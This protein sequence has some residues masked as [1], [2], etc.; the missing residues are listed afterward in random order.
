[1][2]ARHALAPGA[3]RAGSGNRHLG[4]VGGVGVCGGVGGGAS[5]GGGGLGLGLVIGL[6]ALLGLGGCTP[7]RAPPAEAS[8]TRTD[9]PR[10]LSDADRVFVLAAAGAGLYQLE[11]ARLA[12]Q[13]T[14]DP[15]VRNYAAMMQ[16]QYSLANDELRA[17]ARSRGV[18]WPATLPPARQAV[19]TALAAL[20]PEFF[21]RRYVEQTG[22]ADHQADLQLFEAAGRAL[23]DAALRQWALRRV[24]VLQHHL[25]EAQKL[26]LT[27]QAS[28]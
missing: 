4:G 24:P 11:A 8:P 5:G 21:D 7:P 19:L 1:M 23:E 13:H 10:L 14:R 15:R 16:Q 12:E 22:V 9:A 2:R 20:V 28:A 6:V 3:T 25:A 17:L 18:V 27:V 26:P